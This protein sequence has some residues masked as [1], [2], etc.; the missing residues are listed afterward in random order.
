MSDKVIDSVFVTGVTGYVG[1]RL[2]PRLLRAGYHVRVLVRGDSARLNGRLWKEQVEIMVGDV[3]APAE[4]LVSAM[5]GVDAAYYLVH[6][7]RGQSEFSEW[8]MRAAENFASAAAEAGVKRIIYL[9]GLGDAKDDL[10]EH[11]RSRQQTG[12]ILRQFNVPITEFRAGMIVGCGSLSFEMMR[13]LTERLPVMIAPRWVS[14][15]TQPIAVC[16]V[17][18]YLVAALQTPNS[19]GKIIEIGSPD[20][21]TYADMMLIYARI[22]GLR[23]LIIRVPVLTPRLSSYWVHWITPIPAS[24]VTPLIEGLRNELIV[25]DASARLLFPEIEPIT[26]EAAVHLAL[27]RMERGEIETVWSDALASS[28]GDFKLVQMTQER[29]MLLERRQITVDA[30]P[31]AVFRSFCGVGGDRG[32]PPYNWLWRLRGT[33]DRLVGGVGMRRGRRHP[34]KLRQGDAVD[35]WRVES[36]DPDHLLRL[37]AEMKMPGEGWLQFEAFDRSDGRTDLVQ[38]AYFAP[39]GLAG[40]LYWYS[41]YPIHGLIFSQMVAAIANRAVALAQEPLTYNRHGVT[42]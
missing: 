35:F 3:L 28:R 33:M 27:E 20:V 29:G 5:Q 16:D 41:L 34:D 8:D 9:G 10:S 22:R 24:M 30:P 32:W 11:L 40:F 31:E 17:L 38:T 2:V 37:H 21:L 15:K 42:E 13:D 19:Q 6:S 36:V 18:D 23:R 7:M 26:F 1:G 14:T 4:T 25:Q 12:N 39:K